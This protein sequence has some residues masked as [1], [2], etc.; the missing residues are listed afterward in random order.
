[1]GKPISRRALLSAASW[2]FAMFRTARPT[3]AEPGPTAFQLP[4]RH[5]H[6]DFHTSPTITGVGED[7][8]AEDFARV[9]KDAAVNSITIF[10]KCHHGMSYYPTKVGVRHPNLRVDLL[11]ETI[12][13]CH[14]Q[15]IRVPVYISTMYD[16]HVWREHADWRVYD[17]EGKPQGLR[18][19]AAPLKP[20]LGRVC[21]N[22]PYLDYV[23]AQ[24][25]EVLRTYE[26]DGLFYDNFYYPAGGCLGP[27]CMMEREKLGL[28]SARLEDR[29]KHTYMVMERAIDRFAAAVRARRPKAGIY[30]NGSFNMG[31]SPEF[32]RAIVKNYSHIEI[33]SLP[34]GSWGYS[35]F[36]MA[37][38]YL[39][40]FGLEAQGMTGAFHRSWGDFGTVRNQAALDYECFSMLAQATKCAVGDHL[41]PR[42]QINPR[43]YERIGR[44]YR[45][46]VEKEPWCE[47]AKAVTEIASLL[48]LSGPRANDSDIGVTGMLTQL[49]HQ[50]DII[51]R[52]SDFSR[53][54]LL[55][56]P[57]THR[58]DTA[59][60]DKLASY[61][62]SGGALLL[63]HESGLDTAGQGF[64]L[65][66][67][68]LDYEGPWKHESQYLEALEGARDGIPEMVHE[69]YE[70]GSAVKAQPGTTVLARVWT[71]YFDRD[72][73]RFQ[74]EQTPYEKPS[75]Y[76]AAAQ[77][78]KIVYFAV[79]IFR[80]YA[81]NGYA[82][83]R[84]LVGNCIRR[85]MP[86]PLMKAELPST[87]QVT[88]TEQRGRRILH[89][90][91]YIPQRR[92]VD[93]DIVEDV[94]PL[95]NASVA[96][97]I[98]QRPSRVYLA[99]QRQDLKFEYRDGYARATIP[100]INGHQMVVFEA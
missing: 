77:R 94:I 52:A 21:I 97:R 29:R 81:R 18:G 22:T 34:G 30:T 56:L 41:H 55:I 67:M 42:G 66:G 3:W 70:T 48:N 71:G 2:A 32:L 88:M 100:T 20:E 80:T 86:E 37:S 58:L 12:E 46:V 63:S 26:A 40:N 57:D 90:L 78:G 96:A 59:L 4:F 9:L 65:P 92:S 75:D 45:S 6:L 50:F 76:V 35:H 15:G 28:E 1:M 73:K 25:D 17:E 89:V 49:H 23:L 27:S 24:A 84:Q 11:G 10:A 16:Q 7:F 93:L 19:P 43:T 64:A 31:E 95:A 61:V 91:H 44:T 83:Y 13:A 82:V 69:M 79:P 72:Y 47:G 8:R 33:E 51:D 68:G 14:R 98:P 74:V 54:R 53:Y 87:A 85:L 36:Q 99:P 38:R 39:R 62:S 60:R 5:I